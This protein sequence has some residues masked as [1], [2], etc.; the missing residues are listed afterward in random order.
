[1]SAESSLCTFK[2]FSWSDPSFNVLILLLVC[3]WP[4]LLN[5]R[6][7]VGSEVSNQANSGLNTVTVYT[8]RPTATSPVSPQT[9]LCRS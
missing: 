4:S 9:S 6:V 7:G 8:V 2:L 1:M 5:R 3:E